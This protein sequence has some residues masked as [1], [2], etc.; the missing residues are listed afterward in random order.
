MAAGDEE[1]TLLGVV[2]SPFLHRVQIALKL[3]GIEYKYVEDDLNNKSD[4]LLKHNPV[5]KMIPVLI[6]NDKP[7]SESLV[8]VEYI[9]DTW[10]HNPILPSDPYQRALA[11]FWAKFIDDK[12]VAPAWK[13][14]FIVD[15]KEKEKAVEE[16]FEALGFLENELKGKFFGGDEIGFVDIAGVFIPIVQEIA[17]LQLFSSEK[18]PRLYKWSQDFHNHPLVNEV[19]PPKDQLFAYFKARAQSLAAKR[20][21]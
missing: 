20:K 7:I 13:S 2:G 8:I 3:K 9:D 21:N 16:L 12:C 17:G 15:E 18:F 5:Y 19:L 14:A 6:H 4:L 10:K 1:L 11:R